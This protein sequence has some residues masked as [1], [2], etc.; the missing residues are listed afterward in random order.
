MGKRLIIK[1]ADFSTNGIPVSGSIV[2]HTNYSN[3]AMQGS[4][5]FTNDSRFSM[6]PTEITG[7]GLDGVT[8]NIVKLYAAINGTVEIGQATTGNT[9]TY[10]KNHTYQVTQGINTIR[11]T[12]GIT[13]NSSNATIFVSGKNV[14]CYY[15]Q[16]EEP[17]VDQTDKGWLFTPATNYSRI[18]LNLGTES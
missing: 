18:P 1:D 17:S 7:L 15:R 13:L 6:R 9:P 3:L 16:V 14:A 10:S 11:L 4:A 5:A 8:I 2:W 12:E